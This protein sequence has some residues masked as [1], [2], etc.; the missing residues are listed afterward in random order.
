AVA[1]DITARK[2]GEE[3]LR[4]SEERFRVALVHSPITVF[5]H[6]IDL[7]Y[8]WVYN[9]IPG[10][11]IEDM[12]GKRD[13]ELL[14]PQ[15]AAPLMVVKQQVLASRQRVHQ[16]V[17]YVFQGTTYSFDLMVEPLWNAAGQLVG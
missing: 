15:E 2:Q 17:S 11:R 13:D 7:R 6:D 14:P 9:P 10:F 5:H 16:E 1:R 12:L 8:T 4:H 3:A